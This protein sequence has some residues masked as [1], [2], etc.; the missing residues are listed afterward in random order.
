MMNVY[1]YRGFEVPVS[2]SISL[3]AAYVIVD[4]VCMHV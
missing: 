3:G 2:T 1:T 4:N